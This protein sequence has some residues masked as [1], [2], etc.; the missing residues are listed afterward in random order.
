ME[1]HPV[2]SLECN[3]MILAHCNLRLPESGSVAQAGVQWY[4]LGS[5]QP[6]TPWFNSPPWLSDPTASDSQSA[7]ITGMSHCTRLSSFSLL[8]IQPCHD[9]ERACCWIPLKLLTEEPQKMESCYVAQAGFELLSSSDAPTSA[10]Q[11]AEITGGVSLLL[12]RMEC[13]GKILAHCNLPLLG[14]S[15]SPASV[16]GVAGITDEALG[17]VEQQH[18]IP[19]ESCLNPSSQHRQ[20]EETLAR[21]HPCLVQDPSK[22]QT[23]SSGCCW[24]VRFAGA[25]IFLVDCSDSGVHHDDD[26]SLSIA[27]AGVQWLDLGSLQP[28]PPGFKRSSLSLPSSW[29]YRRAPPCQ[30]NF[31]IFSTAD[32]A[33][34]VPGHLKKQPRAAVLTTAGPCS[35]SSGQLPISTPC[36]Q[37][38]GSRP[39]PWT[40]GT[41]ELHLSIC[42]QGWNFALSPRLE[43]N[44]MISAHCNLRLLGSINSPTSASR[45]AGI[46]GTCHHARLIFAFLVES[47]SIAQAGVQWCD[48]GSLQPPSLRFQQFFCLSLLKTG[49]HHVSQAG[50]NILNSSDLP[51]LA[52]QS[53]GITGAAWELLPPT[54]SQLQGALGTQ[55]CRV[56]G[57]PESIV[58]ARREQLSKNQVKWAFAGITCVSV[59]V[60]AVMVL[61]ITLRRSGCELEACSCDAN[62]LDYLLSLGQISCQDALEVTWN[63][64]SN[65]KKAMTAALNSNVT[66]QEADVNVEGLAQPMRQSHHA[67]LPGHLQQQHT[68]AVA[69]P[70]AGLFKLYFKNIKAM[71]PSLDLLRQLIEEGKVRWPAWINADILNST[72]MPISIEVNAVHFLAL[73]QKYPKATL[74]PGWTTLYVPTLPNRM[75]TGAIVEKMCELVGVVSQR[76]TFPVWSS[77]VQ[78]S[79][80]HFSWLLSQPERYSLMLSQA[81]SDPMLMED[82]LCLGQHHCPPCL[83]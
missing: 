62:L 40:A 27:Q 15:N 24:V 18:T 31:C 38:A 82:L 36:T 21:E 30:A 25:W 73:V 69:G 26:E 1:S 35:G 72:N 29:D 37:R 44:D 77:M 51:A 19:A 49:F 33:F 56:G 68:G 32:V 75:D 53:V 66:V 80:P 6:P 63:H 43:C 7:G 79:Q 14:S 59:V 64:A 3:G 55:P 8:P 74:S 10:S 39:A 20:N 45:V 23:T 4:D 42:P 52:S 60:N 48:V 58:M 81:A 46:T 9:S 22:E 71:V 70:C 50:P 83:L 13:N 16:S 76:V 65:S 78:A 47:H 17:L 41:E 61:A 54:G 28:P 5:V 12:P 2:A 34:R 11:S 67:T 57:I